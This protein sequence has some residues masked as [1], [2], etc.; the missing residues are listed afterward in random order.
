MMFVTLYVVTVVTFLALDAIMLNAVVAPV[1]RRN[2][3]DRMLEVPKLGAAAVFYLFYVAGL[4]VLVSLP[5]VDAP[6][7][8]LWQGAL[9]GAI[10]YGTYEM[11]NYATLKDWSLR[12]VALD[13]AWGTALTGTSAWVGVTVARWLHG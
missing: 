3:G 11:T 2:L 13:W 9:L 6:L 12:M 10:A 4:V 1:F 5:N 7:T 8:V